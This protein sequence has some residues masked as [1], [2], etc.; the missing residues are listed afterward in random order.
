MD[1]NCGEAELKKAKLKAMSILKYRD[2][3][4]KE[5]RMKL[6]Q[7]GFLESVIDA[8]VEYVISFH[9]IDDERYTASYI[10]YK[11]DLKSIRQMQMELVEKGIPKDM[12]NRVIEDQQVSEEEAVRRAIK[13]RTEDVDT[14]P[15]E[16]KQKLIASLYRKGFSQ[17]E[18]K[19]QIKFKT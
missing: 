15:Q 16:L 13:K 9:Y 6:K 17:E 4:E 10:R 1:D 7:A 11:K 2:R 5:L 3:T 12:F 19:R 18:I 14:L 8:A